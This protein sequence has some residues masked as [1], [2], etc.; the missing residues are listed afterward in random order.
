MRFTAYVGWLVHKLPPPSAEEETQ[1]FKTLEGKRMSLQKDEFLLIFGAI[2][3][4]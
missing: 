4:L 3:N 1:N 2:H